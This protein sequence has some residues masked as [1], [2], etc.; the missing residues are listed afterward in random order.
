LTRYLY[1]TRDFGKSWAA[2]F[3][4]EFR[5][6]LSNCVREDPLR[7]GLLVRVHE[8]SVY[9]SFMMAIVAV[10]AAQYADDFRFAIWWC[11]ATILVIATHGRSF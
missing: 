10:A 2:G 8:K 6:K 11:K 9:V 3:E 5:G 4:R 7:K 1:R